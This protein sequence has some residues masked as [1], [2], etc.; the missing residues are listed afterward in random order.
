[1]WTS[2]FLSH[3]RRGPKE[4][5][6]YPECLLCAKYFQESHLISLSSNLQACIDFPILQTTTAATTK[7]GG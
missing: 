7:R 3:A 1:M 2:P 4:D 5:P 6:L